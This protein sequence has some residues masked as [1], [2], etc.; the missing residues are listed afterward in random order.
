MTP[1]TPT[2]ADGPLVLCVD[3]EP[4]NLQVLGPLLQHH[5]F[6]VAFALD[7]P[8]GLSLAVENKP[9][10]ILLDVSMPGM[11]G[12]AV[13]RTLQADVRTTGVPVIFLTART[14]GADIVA[15]FKAGAVDYVGKPFQAE[16]LIARVTV[17]TQLRRLRGLLTICCHCH[18]IRNEEHAWERMES[19][20]S[21]H[22]DAS[23]SHGLCPTCL[24]RHYA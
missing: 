20:V 22:T 8:K 5:G 23:F 2:T 17:H 11:D 15:G 9:D 14:A 18:Q 7:G 24:A 19:Y 6:R 16:E 1:E 10:L 3:D 21:R 4:R 13:C 12:L